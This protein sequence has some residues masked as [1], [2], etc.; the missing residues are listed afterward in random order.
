[1]KGA[2]WA[3]LALAIGFGAG[4]FTAS[5]G[6]DGPDGV[7]PATSDSLAAAK[8]E[9]AYLEEAR[10]RSVSKARDDSIAL[11]LLQS[12]VRV[13]ARRETNPPI[14]GT[15]RP[16]DGTTPAL[17]DTAT[18]YEVPAPVAALVTSLER[19]VVSVTAALDTTALQLH[20]E[21]NARQLAESIAR[22]AERALEAERRRRWRYRIEGAVGGGI[23]GGLA[24]ILI[25]L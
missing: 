19:R 12:R 8:V 21:R 22:Q 1:M 16:I 4:V 15:E 11:A 2:G 7:D 5:R 10:Q 25:L 9:I 14:G 13:V 6:S 24:V 3:L 18:V 23:V 17:P 20:A